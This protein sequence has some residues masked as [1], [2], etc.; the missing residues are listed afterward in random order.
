MLSQNC[1]VWD[2]YEQTIFC[3]P[4]AIKTKTQFKKIVRLIHES[5]SS[6]ASTIPCKIV[7]KSL[8]SQLRKKMTL[9]LPKFSERLF[10]SLENFLIN[11]EYSKNNGIVRLFVR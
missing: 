7:T 4:A 2:E 11:K 6:D 1:N 8:C 10:Y 3:D 9:K 5:S